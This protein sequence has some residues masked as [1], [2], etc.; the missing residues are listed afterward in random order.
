MRKKLRLRFVKRVACVFMSLCVALQGSICYAGKGGKSKPKKPEMSTCCGGGPA[1]EADVAEL[2]RLISEL[3]RMSY[4]IQVRGFSAAAMSR[5]ISQEEKFEFN[6]F[7]MR[8]SDFVS[9]IML[10]PSDIKNHIEGVKLLRYAMPFLRLDVDPD[11]M[12]QQK[13]WRFVCAMW[14]SVYRT[15][16]ASHQ[17][18]D[19]RLGVPEY[20][21]L[22]TRFLPDYLQKEANYI[23]ETSESISYAVELCN[24][25]ECDEVYRLAFSSTLLIIH[26]IAM[27]VSHDWFVKV[28]ST[29]I[30]S[31]WSGS[32]YGGD[33]CMTMMRPFV[34]HPEYFESGD[35]SS[36]VFDKWSSC[37][38]DLKYPNIPELLGY[39]EQLYNCDDFQRYLYASIWLFIETISKFER[40]L[41]ASREVSR[42]ERK[43]AEEIHRAMVVAKSILASC[44]DDDYVEV[45]KLDRA[46]VI[47]LDKNLIEALNTIDI[48]FSQCRQGLFMP[49]PF[50]NFYGVA[51]KHLSKNC[52][53][54]GDFI[55]KVT[56]YTFD[57]IRA[58][59]DRQRE[60]LEEIKKRAKRAREESEALL[61]A[62]LKEDSCEALAEV[63]LDSKMS[64]DSK[65][66]V[67]DDDISDVPS[68]EVMAE[69]EAD[70]GAKICSD[71]E[72]DAICIEPE[73]PK[74]DFAS[75]YAR[76]CEEWKAHVR[77]QRE[78]KEEAQAQQ[79]RS[80]LASV[81]HDSHYTVVFL[82]ERGKNPMQYIE[83]HPEYREKWE[84][85]LK[86]A[87]DGMLRDKALPYFSNA[88]FYEQLPGSPPI[89]IEP[90]LGNS[91]ENGLREARYM[92]KGSKGL[93]IVYYK[94]KDTD[95]VVVMYLGIPFGKEHKNKHYT[96]KI[97]PNW[98]F[99]PSL[100][101][102]SDFSTSSDSG[103]SPS[104]SGSDSSTS[105]KSSGH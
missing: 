42:L 51:L 93:R 24:S 75:I 79:R 27:S 77:Q 100:P 23:Y 86:N 33:L 43:D 105:S 38:R 54:E 1:S 19:S 12:E 59:V 6:V 98:E 15:L 74:I 66:H 22:P 20:I 102:E 4:R 21:R 49:F 96:I 71:D 48:F 65:T 76:R 94:E 17:K 82:C 41:F 28:E 11:D 40:K 61:V 78:A 87:R 29:P 30:V 56:S 46:D 53:Y 60:A 16:Q 99:V 3:N 34:S 92:T 5:R 37:G 72:I 73:A 31:C 97:G 45:L 67:D 55:R 83:D 95:R 26:N 2:S 88:P 52:C 101:L 39:M 32:L 64:G 91:G 25:R 104:G 81:P 103:S 85:W 70:G 9:D 13:F 18:I 10:E 84:K 36:G 7:A 69:E 47:I 90:W 44:Y 8:F 58:K 14:V 63:D 62:K 68:Q 50:N 89:N 35:V 57:R 80:L